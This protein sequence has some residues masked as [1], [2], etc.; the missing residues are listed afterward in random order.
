[1]P[2]NT[3]TNT[4]DTGTDLSPG[5]GGNTPP[6]DTQHATET[7]TRKVRVQRRNSRLPS[8]P[9]AWIAALLLAFGTYHI[10]S[11]AYTL[12]YPRVF[13]H[14]LT[15]FSITTLIATSIL[16]VL[17]VFIT[18]F[19]IALLLKLAD[20]I[21]PQNTHSYGPHEYTIIAGAG[22]LAAL[23][24]TATKILEPIFT[25]VTPPGGPAETILAAFITAIPLTTVMIE[26]LR[27]GAIMSA[28]TRTGDDTSTR[29]GTTSTETSSG[30]SSTRN[31][32][33]LAEDEIRNATEIRKGNP[34]PVTPNY[35]GNGA[36]PTP[37]RNNTNNT[38]SGNSNGNNS[39][40]SGSG[41]AGVQVQGGYERDDNGYVKNVDAYVS[42][43]EFEYDWQTDT[44]VTF[45]DIGGMTDLKHELRTEVIRPYEERERAEE[46]GIKPPNIVFHGPPG[47]GKTYTAKAL[48]SELELPFAKLSGADLQSKWINESSDKVKTMFDEAKQLAGETGGAVVFLDE[49][50]TVLKKRNGGSGGG[51]EEDNKVVN[52]FLNHLEDTAENNI[53]FV[54]ATNRLDALDDAGIRSGRIDKKI[55][56]GKPDTKARKKVLQMHLDERNHSVSE[57]DVEDIAQKTGGLVAADLAA[58]VEKAAF[59]VFER[60]GDHITTTDLYA[61]LQIVT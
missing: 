31:I 61:A 6:D 13:L 1:M 5:T 27:P 40:A 43:T 30:G 57:T 23:I 12:A 51:H 33:E 10:T 24:S 53:V 3:P 34:Q 18:F 45:D 21:A 16:I 4:T 11:Y 38:G 44:G 14:V 54:G 48:A 59:R 52:E 37:T 7:R 60:D 55:L 46:L 41:N 22:A 49:L 58:L 29:T 8:S 42:N 26:Y 19:A 9:R 28:Y 32:D 2:D 25:S 50:D 39:D 36:N 56:V 17:T 47:T 15:G 20:V 35:P